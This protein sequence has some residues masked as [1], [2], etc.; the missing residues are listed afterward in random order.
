MCNV[1][2]KAQQDTD[3]ATY[4]VAASAA[5]KVVRMIDVFNDLDMEKL[6]TF[7]QENEARGFDSEITPFGCEE[8]AGRLY[9]EITARFAELP[10]SAPVNQFDPRHP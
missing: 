5:R 9:D 3:H 7:K 1:C 8:E 10:A 2:E 4:F 6:A